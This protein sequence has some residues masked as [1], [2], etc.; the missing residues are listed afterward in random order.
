MTSTEKNLPSVSDLS[1]EDALA[2]LQTI[3]SALEEETVDVDLLAS[4]VARADEVI[5]HCR[6]RI[7]VA[8]IQVERV[9]ESFE[10]E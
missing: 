7:D 1:Y 9:V 8:R 10:Q 3:L 2:E 6:N 4:Q 5:H